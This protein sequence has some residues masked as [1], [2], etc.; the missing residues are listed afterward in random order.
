M[1]PNVGDVS[2]YLQT[3][4]NDFT[5]DILL[6]LGLFAGQVER[7]TSILGPIIISPS[8]VDGEGNIESSS[9]PFSPNTGQS[10]PNVVN[11]ISSTELDPTTPASNMS[12]LTN[13]EKIKKRTPARA[14]KL[15]GDIYLLAGR[16]DLAIGW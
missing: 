14:Q 2:F 5:S 4:I 10:T 11:A 8:F 6:A 7:K 12:T 1:I 16:L 9:Q 3:M 13:P 15:L